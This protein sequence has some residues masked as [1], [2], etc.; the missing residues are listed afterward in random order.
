[1]ICCFALRRLQA[2]SDRTRESYIFHV[3]RFVSGRMLIALVTLLAR[4]CVR[5][6][7][8]DSKST[9]GCLGYREAWAL[10]FCNML[11]ASGSVHPRAGHIAYFICFRVVVS[12]H[13]RT[14][15]RS[16]FRRSSSQ[17]R[18]SRTQRI[19]FYAVRYPSC[20]G[21]GRSSLSAKMDRTLT[22]LYISY[23]TP[24]ARHR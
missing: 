18:E 6:V 13:V 11:G 24:S 12:V 16:L 5:V 14:G 15:R 7:M 8:S 23:G 22:N 2:W 17:R 21:T 19:H 3:R 20:Q 4:A 9:A 1:V 10:S